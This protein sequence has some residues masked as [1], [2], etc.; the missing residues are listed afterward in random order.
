[1]NHLLCLE[2]WLPQISYHQIKS[3]S[4]PFWIQVHNLPLEHMNV[5]N[6][7]KLLQK[8]GEVLEIENPIVDG[9]L[10][11]TFIRG[12]VKLDLDKPLPIGCWAP[13]SN[14]P[15]LW[16]TYKY[17]RLQSLCYKCGIIGHDQKSCPKPTVMSPLDP[18]KPKFGLDLSVQAPRS[19]HF[20]GR[21]PRKL[22]QTQNNPQP[23]Q[24]TTQDTNPSQN[25]SHQ[26][27]QATNEETYPKT[28]RK[29][30]QDI[31]LHLH[32]TPLLNLPHLHHLYL[33]L[34]IVLYLEKYKMK[35]LNLFLKAT[36]KP[37]FL[38]VP[39]KKEM[40]ITLIFLRCLSLLLF[41]NLQ[42]GMALLNP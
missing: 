8:I 9:N 16:I 2:S 29:H 19:I 4:S 12:R 28:L 38:K 17:E 30:Y 26:T 1:M 10:L 14:L 27:S 3:N 21:N 41:L 23:H 35:Q 24:T 15:N 18:N 22:N 39:I 13:K 31:A 33:T 37:H 40:S 20:L 7:W 36:L 42:L 25:P 5:F 32:N 34:T 6:A 11:R